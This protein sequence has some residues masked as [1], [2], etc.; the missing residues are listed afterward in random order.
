MKYAPYVLAATLVVVALPA[1]AAKVIDRVVAVVNDDIILDS[2]VDQYAVPLLRGPLD[3]SN[4]DGKKKWLELKHKALDALIDSKLIQQQATELKLTV[5]N[6][7]VE[8]AWEEVK[9]QNNLDDSTFAE[10]LKSQGFTPESY[11]KS[12]KRQM[13][14]LKVVN[15]AVRSRVSVS[16]EEVKTYYSQNERAM[17]G[18]KTAHLRQIL[19]AVP[20]DAS[21]ADVD[22][23]KK[24]AEGIVSQARKGTSFVELAKKYSDDD[25]TKADGGDLGW[26]GKGVLQDA[27]DDAIGGMDAGDVRGPIRT[28]RGFHVIQLV[29]RKAGDMRPFDE[30]KDQIRKQLY[31]QQVEKASQSWLKELRK[32][33]HVDVRL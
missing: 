28:G 13:L 11:R 26:I 31:D 5:T 7:E 20:P 25:L 4:D 23:K 19:V 32:K 8:R 17:S 16:D 29:E 10:A 30:V 12:L 14:E 15:T 22:R 33:A 6:D 21:P 3:T 9:K 18:D 27:L 24:V 1:D 2:E